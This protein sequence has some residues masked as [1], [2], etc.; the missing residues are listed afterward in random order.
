VTAFKAQKKYDT[1]RSYIW[2]LEW[3]A[4]TVWSEGVQRAP[5]PRSLNTKQ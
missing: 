3:A 5:C 2:A 4:Y 1:F